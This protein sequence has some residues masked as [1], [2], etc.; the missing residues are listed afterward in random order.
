MYEF[1]SLVV[2]SLRKKSLIRLEMVAN[3]GL[4]LPPNLLVT[5]RYPPA[6]PSNQSKDSLK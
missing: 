5:P 4:T 1:R 3:K 6:K 2:P